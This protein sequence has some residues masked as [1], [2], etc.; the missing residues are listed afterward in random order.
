MKWKSSRHLPPYKKLSVRF[1]ADRI[2]AEYL[3]LKESRAFDGYRD[4]YGE[5][6]AI[7]G[8]RK[9]TGELRP[10]LK[11][12]HYRNLAL[13]VFEPEYSLE[14]RQEKSGS[15]WDTSIPFDNP[16]LDERF[17][18]RRLPGI[19]TYLSEV[20]DYFSPYVHRARFAKLIA[21]SKISAHVDYDAK[22]SVRIAIPVIS[23][24]HCWNLWRDPA[25]KQTTEA[26]LQADGSAYFLNS[27]IPHW[28]ENRSD[29][30]RVFLLLSVDSQACLED[31]FYANARGGSLHATNNNP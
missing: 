13:T 31:E 10:E 7:Y 25:T 18:R 1:D 5:L 30:D 23:N 17:Y 6:C 12:G 21:G 3:A 28:A 19:P 11:E 22:Y 14:M 4:D 20:L 24:P 26:V 15:H 8:A 2:R 27:G 29:E 16:K 9:G